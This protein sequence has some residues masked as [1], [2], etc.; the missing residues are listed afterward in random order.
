MTLRPK[1]DATS[2]TATP[3]ARSI[4]AAAVSIFTSSNLSP[5]Y[6]ELITSSIFE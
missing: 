3:L 1:Q 6:L 5:L 4:F 2:L